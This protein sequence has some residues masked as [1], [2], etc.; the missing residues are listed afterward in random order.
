MV[1]KRWGAHTNAIFDLA[2]NHADNDNSLI[3]A[4][5]DQSIRLWKLDRL[6]TPVSTFR[7]HNGS[8]KEVSFKTHDPRKLS[9]CALLAILP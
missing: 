9:S 3:T 8:V 4:S 1:Q 7:G 5:G 6:D 2:W